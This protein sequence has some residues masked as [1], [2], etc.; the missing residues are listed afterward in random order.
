M[1]TVLSSPRRFGT[2]GSALSGAAVGRRSS[3]AMLRR[4]HRWLSTPR[5]RALRAVLHRP[6]LA[7][8]REAGAMQV[9]EAAAVEP[10]LDAGDALVVDV[11]VADEVRDLGA[12]GIDPL[13][14]GEEADA[15][16]AQSVN[17]VLL[18]RRDLALEPDEAA[19]RGEALA[20]LR[21]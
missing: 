4:D 7:V 5:A 19:A 2:S 11:D 15:R 16:D 3:W 14:L 1:V 10:F 8:G 21:G 18:L 17:L 6:L 20:H 12:V 9:G 13:V